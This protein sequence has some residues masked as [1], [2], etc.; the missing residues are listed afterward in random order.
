[1]KLGILGTGKIVQ[2]VLPVLKQCNLQRCYLLAREGSALR[3]QQLCAQYQL[4]GYFL[5]IE[6]L[7]SADI[8][9]VY[10]A[11]PNHLHFS[12]ARQAIAAGKH[13]IL[14]KP[15]TPTLAELEILEEEAQEQQ[16][17]LLEA[18]NIHATPAFRAI[19][20]ALPL[21][22]TIRLINFQFCQYSSRYDDFLRDIIAPAFDPAAYGGAL[23]DLNVYNLHAILALFGSPGRAVYT[24]TLQKGIDTSGIAT[25]HYGSF[26]A[27]AMAAKDAQAPTF[28]TIIGEKGCLSIPVSINKIDRFSLSLLGQP[29]E[30]FVFPLQHHRLYDEFREFGRIIR[31]RD[32]ERAEDLLIISLMAARLLEELRPY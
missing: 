3:A 17:F 26:Q 18:M 23:M 12:F 24:P 1:M 15:A 10:V 7:L 29:T 2:E 11:L 30:E 6:E 31:E 19:K 25:L 9:T 13:V 14:E 32:E 27:V 21:L 4:D 16:V 5:H 22:G 8:D 28:S 20:E